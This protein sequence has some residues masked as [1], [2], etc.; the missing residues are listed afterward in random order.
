[1]GFSQCLV[2]ILLIFKQFPGT[3]LVYI[4][5]LFS[6]LAT[7]ASQVTKQRNSYLFSYPSSKEA[8]SIS[9]FTIYYLFAIAANDDYDYDNGGNDMTVILH[10]E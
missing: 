3:I 4:K 5:S 10:D 7:K 9:H 6:T 8:I 2:S 1:M